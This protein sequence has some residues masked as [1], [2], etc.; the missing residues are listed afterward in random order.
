MADKGIMINGKPLEEHLEEE[1][2]REI[3]QTFYQNN[4]KHSPYK[5]VHTTRSVIYKSKKAIVVKSPEDQF[6]Y[7]IDELSEDIQDKFFGMTEEEQAEV[8]FGWSDT[9]ISSVDEGINR[10]I[11]LINI[12]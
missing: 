6:M 11:N 1:H 12:I 8:W 4:S 10:L 7:F 2:S 5:R 9:R 3:R